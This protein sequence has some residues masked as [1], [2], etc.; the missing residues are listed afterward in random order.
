MDLLPIK[1]PGPAHESWMDCQ[2]FGHKAG[3]VRLAPDKLYFTYYLS[4]KSYPSSL[5]QYIPQFVS[6]KNTAHLRQWLQRPH[7]PG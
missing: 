1:A 5:P 7:P 2:H 4:N 6:R 3:K